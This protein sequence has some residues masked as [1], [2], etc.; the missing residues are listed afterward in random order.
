MKKSIKTLRLVGVSFL[1]IFFVFFLIGAYS[2]PVQIELKKAD[3]SLLFNFS[4]K[5]QENKKSKAL[6]KKAIQSPHRDTVIVNKNTTAK[7]Q[8]AGKI[9]NV[10]TNEG[11]E[12]V[13]LIG[14]SQLEGLRNPVSAYCEKNNHVLVATIIWYGSSTKQWATTD[15]LKYYLDLYQPTVVLFAI[16]LN[17]LFVRDL[18]MRTGYIRTIKKTFE[19]YHIPYSWI[20]PAAWT[21]DKGII[22]VM[23]RENGDHFF[24]SH[25]LKLERANDKRHPSKSASKIW[26]DEVAKFITKSG[27]IDFSNKVDT[28]PKLKFSRTILLK[29]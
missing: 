24:S 10:V 2:G 6:Q 26:F 17:E 19:D 11:V 16:G 20:G 18:E 7:K 22:E 13:L 25:L 21:A 15:T 9:S 29:I 12:R 4:G 28:L 8:S 23:S 3:N 14:D 1:L 5:N 27:L